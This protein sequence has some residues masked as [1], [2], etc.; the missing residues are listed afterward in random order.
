MTYIDLHT[1]TSFSDGTDSPAH[2]V[3]KAADIGL[4]AV[5]ITDHDTVAGLSEA[6]EQ[7]RLCGIEVVRGCELSV[8]ADV[9]TSPATEVHLLGLFLP[10]NEAIQEFEASLRRLRE[11]RT[12]RNKAIVDKLRQ[13]GCNITY[14]EVCALACGESIGRPHMARLL[15]QK[16]HVS[17]VRE[18]FAKYLGQKGKSFVPKQVLSLA[19]GM[20]LLKRTGAVVALAHPGLIP[21]S[22]SWLDAFVGH[23]S[24]L[25][26]HAIEAYHSEHSP[27]AVQLCVHLAH[28]YMLGITGGSDY[29]GKA[30]P[31]IHLGCGKG[32]LRIPDTLLHPLKI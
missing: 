24:T 6:E 9:S 3:S 29:H 21:C 26:L 17:S 27:A 4:S 15:M 13:A 30:K 16:G 23:L 19:E 5:A 20:A 14:D 31:Q 8:S 7:G 12:V 2:L 10:Q 25:G 32:N 22:A 1:H 11:F 18:A 28:K